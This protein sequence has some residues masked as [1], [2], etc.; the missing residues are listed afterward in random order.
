[1]KNYIN[2]LFRQFCLF[3]LFANLA[4]AQVNFVQISSNDTAYCSQVIENSTPGNFDVNTLGAAMGPT[5][6]KK[7]KNTETPNWS[8]I[9][10]NSIPANDITINKS[11][12]SFLYN[13]K[14][15]IAYINSNGLSIVISQWDASTNQYTAI[16]PLL[17]PTYLGNFD[18]CVNPIT[19]EIYVS[20]EYPITTT[21]INVYHYDG[22]AWVLDLPQFNPFGISQ[23]LNHPEIYFNDSTLYLAVV[24]P[25]IDSLLIYKQ[26]Y[27]NFNTANLIPVTAS[28]PISVN[29][30]DYSM[31]GIPGQDPYFATYNNSTGAISLSNIQANVITFLGGTSLP[32]T[33][34][35]K[36]N[37][38]FKNGNPEIL[39]TSIAGGVG[40]SKILAL[41]GSSLTSS[42]PD[43]ANITGTAT[44]N[45]VYLVSSANG[46]RN[47]ASITSSIGGASSPRSVVYASNNKPSISNSSYEDTI[48]HVTG[49]DYNTRYIGEITFNDMDGDPVYITDI[50]AS[51]QTVLEIGIFGYTIEKTQSIGGLTTYKI[52]AINTQGPG[53]ANLNIVYSDGYELDTLTFN[54]IHSL[55]SV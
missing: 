23:S 33:T 27:T 41:N 25:F 38:A 9:S 12:K 49:A 3:C 8:T 36:L 13:G 17:T 10:S 42:L 21:S 29:I 37:L 32:P 45:N 44:I 35:A 31:E 39:T 52:T 7:Y 47:F 20:C 55:S 18:V 53:V 30:S 15:T 48:C 4:T 19:H 43:V 34:I 6:Y 2:P 28:N 51:D 40:T 24:N 50:I 5:I 11:F 26:N 14:P 46:L 16:L 1:M 22:S 54:A